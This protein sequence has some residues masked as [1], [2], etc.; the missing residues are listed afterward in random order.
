MNSKQT[1]TILIILVALL[2]LSNVITYQWV[3][4][5][6]PQVEVPDP[7]YVTD[8]VYAKKYFTLLDKY[9][10][11]SLKWKDIKPKTI[12]KWK[13]PK[14]VWP[15]VITLVPDSIILKIGKLEEEIAI[16]KGYITNFPKSP[17]LLKLEASKDSLEI[18]TI[19]IASHLMTYS[20]P[21]YYDKYT[22]VWQNNELSA[23][24]LKIKKKIETDFRN[25]YLNADYDLF[26]QNPSIY[27]D[28]NIDIGRMRYGTELRGTFTDKDPVGF[29]VNV[30]YRLLK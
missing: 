2:I 4:R 11:D 12:T 25:L 16:H 9:N 30:G 5:K 22:Y 23:K 14:P 21:V 8:T 24:K 27:L 1:N 29:R 13:E 18:S 7:V 19:D 15:T 10:K 17:K 28:Y 3:R 6:N 26:S 20:Y